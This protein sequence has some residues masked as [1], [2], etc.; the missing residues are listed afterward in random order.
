MA[1]GH[2]SNLASR[3]RPPRNLHGFRPVQLG[4][5]IVR[6]AKA[7]ENRAHAERRHPP[8]LGLPANQLPHRACAQVVVVVVGDEHRIQPRQVAQPHGRPEEPPGACPL[9]RGR[10][11]VPNRVEQDAHAVDLH[12]RGRVPEPGHAQ[13]ARRWRCIYP[14]IGAERP[15]PPPRNALPPV[16]QHLG[17]HPE[18]H[19]RAAHRGWNRVHIGPPHL[20]RPLQHSHTFDLIRPTSH[21]YIAPTP[22]PSPRLGKTPQALPRTSSPPRGASA[23]CWASVRWSPPTTRP[24]P[25][26]SA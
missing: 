6:H 14:G 9:E 13:P 21:R 23:S 12:Q 19:S 4:D 7:L 22:S 25:A 16:L 2:G 17:E 5:A 10:T 18:D 15:E 24:A 3:T 20:L 1:R 8:C 11:R 26:R